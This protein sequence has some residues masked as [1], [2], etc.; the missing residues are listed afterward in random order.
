LDKCS[1]IK[2]KGHPWR[3]VWKWRMKVVDSWNLKHHVIS[4]YKRLRKLKRR[5]ITE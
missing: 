3:S 2:T 5:M 4:F 1:L